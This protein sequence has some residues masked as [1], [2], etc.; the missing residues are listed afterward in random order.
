MDKMSTSHLWVMRA[1]FVGLAFLI[2]FFHLLPL[3]T[4]PSRW[5]PPDL[6]VAFSFAWVLRRPSFVPVMLLAGVMLMADFMFSRPPGLMAML[7]VLGAEYLK[8]R[9]AGMSEASFAGEWAAVALALVGIAVLNRVVLGVLGVDQ[10]RVLLTLSELLLTIAIYPL[11][12][13]I[14]HFVMGVRKLAPS[15]ADALGVRA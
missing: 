12:A 1:A 2:M 14:T 13:L 9:A 3:S 7:V 8:T 5:A 4:L 6:L 11:V 10:A 15:D